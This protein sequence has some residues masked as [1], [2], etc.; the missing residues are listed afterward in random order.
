MV[1]GGN[2]RASLQ[3]GC[4]SEKEIQIWPA[5]PC[6]TACGKR[7]SATG[8]PKTLASPGVVFDVLHA[9]GDGMKTNS[10][11]TLRMTVISL[12][13]EN[14]SV[15]HL[16]SPVSG[17]IWL[18]SPCRG[19]ARMP[20]TYHAGLGIFSFLQWPLGVK[21]HWKCGSCREEFQARAVQ[22]LDISECNFISG[23]TN[24]LPLAC[25]PRVMKQRDK[26]QGHRRLLKNYLQINVRT[27]C[28]S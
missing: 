14:D 23:I 15:A 11:H 3:R 8:P 12:A 21:W 4:C 24:A 22:I 26:R 5:G 9:H 16:C 17:W 27:R 13:Q 10:T 18:E 2:D 20:D 1:P 6:W 19:T 7:G 25:L 28:M